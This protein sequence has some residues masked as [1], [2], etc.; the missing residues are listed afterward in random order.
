MRA[1]II[2]GGEIGFALAQ[3]LSERNEVF[4]VDHA[5][6]VADRFER[7]DV[8]F[9][10]GTATS[11]DVLARAGVDRADVLVACTGLD[12]VNIVCCAVARQ[13]GSPRTT[14][15]VSREDFVTLGGDAKGLAA[16]GIDRVIWPEAQL[17][18]DI[19][20]IIREPGALDAESFADGAI[21]LVEYRLEAGSPLA[22]RRIAALHLP[23]SS[24][25]VAVRRGDA[26]FI[27]RGNSELAAGD[28]AVVMGTPDALHEVR[29]L[30]TGFTEADRQRVTIV[31]GGDVGFQL[32]ERLEE[33]GGVEVMVI[34]R[35]PD[36]GEMIAARL[37]RALVLNG[38]G[39]DL[40]LL[41]TEDVG[42]SDVLVGVIDNDERNLLASLLGRQLGARRII[43]RVGKRANLRLFERVGIDVPISARGA[44]VASVL[45]QISGGSTRL[46]AVIEQGAGRILE[47]DVPAG[48]QPRELR[49]LAPPL[50][51]IVGAIIRQSRAFVPRGDHRIEPGDRLIVFTTYEA[52]DKVRDYFTHVKA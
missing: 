15:F 37:K 28:K 30:M 46:L 19:E 35:N 17:A 38:D 3:A 31:G 9:V 49:N 48:Y 8:Q 40:E 22:G 4:V 50:N 36:R 32:A 2:G 7:L 34:E 23:H 13:L 41:E 20:R 12:E 1:V 43:T 25:I 24:V 18:E 10:L 26:F 51:S 52:S 27:P 39:T 33:D 45:H 11:R 44:A 29:H 47:L 21:R 42:R 14:C 6:E 16:F 5:P